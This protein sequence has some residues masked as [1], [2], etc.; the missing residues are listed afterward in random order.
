[1]ASR[2]AHATPIQG[3]T[4]QGWLNI[5]SRTVKPLARGAVLI[6]IQPR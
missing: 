1:M 6:P 3:A 4:E 5:Y 2:R